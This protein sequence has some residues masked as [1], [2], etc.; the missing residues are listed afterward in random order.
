MKTFYTERDIEELHTNGV[1]KIEVD[2]DVILTDLARE[3][4]ERLGIQLKVVE[5][6]QE[7]IVR[8]MFRALGSNSAASPSKATPSTPP[9]SAPVT[10]PKT[11]SADG[12]LVQHI[13]ARVIARLG[14][15]EY[16]NV[17]DQVIPQV[18][19]RLTSGSTGTAKNGSDY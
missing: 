16:N 8:R 14:T 15:T 9:S 17:L 1:T 10:T 5:Q 2:D 12:D 13:K 7:Q 3:K 19:A 18:L 4:A 6:R 11:A